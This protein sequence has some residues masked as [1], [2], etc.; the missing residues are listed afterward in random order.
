MTKLQDLILRV[1][2]IEKQADEEEDNS[3]TP[4]A[5]YVFLANAFG[6]LVAELLNEIEERDT[7]LGNVDGIID[8]LMLA[9]KDWAY[10][11]LTPLDSASTDTPTP[12]PTNG[13]L[14]K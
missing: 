12:T 9:V 5:R 2:S 4:H 11:G 3:I 7:V 1:Q 13:W 6:G 14:G 10:L 8:Q